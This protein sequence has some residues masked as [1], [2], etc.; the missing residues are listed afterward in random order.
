MRCHRLLVAHIHSP[1][2]PCSHFQFSAHVPHPGC[3]A[4]FAFSLPNSIVLTP[5]FLET[6]T[7]SNH[8]KPLW[9]TWLHNSRNQFASSKGF[10]T[11]QVYKYLDSLCPP[12]FQ[13]HTQDS[14]NFHPCVVLDLWIKSEAS[15]WFGS[16]LVVVAVGWLIGLVFVCF[17][18]NFS[19][20]IHFCFCF[21]AT[22]ISHYCTICGWHW[23]SIFRMLFHNKPSL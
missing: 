11:N 21:N 13:P 1:R 7:N 19:T 4:P 12:S 3:W 16:V 20:G 10:L 8:S 17:C 2:P 6:I 22:F 23:L 5:R 14:L 15:S 18:N 9:L